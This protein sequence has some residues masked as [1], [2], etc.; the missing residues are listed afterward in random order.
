MLSVNIAFIV[1]QLF[2]VAS[3]SKESIIDVSAAVR[4]TSNKIE[5]CTQQVVELHVNQVSRLLPQTECS[6]VTLLV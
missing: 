2:C 4:L 5:S 6:A 3:I 1:T